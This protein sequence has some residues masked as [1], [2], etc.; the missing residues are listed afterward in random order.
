MT[1]DLRDCREARCCPD[2]FLMASGIGYLMPLGVIHPWCHGDTE[3]SDPFCGIGK[4]VVAGKSSLQCKTSSQCSSASEDI[5]EPWRLTK[6]T[7]QIHRPSWP[8]SNKKH[9][10]SWRCYFSGLYIYRSYC[11]TLIETSSPLLWHEGYKDTLREASKFPF[12]LVDW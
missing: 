12:S 2:A 7:K 9:P 5:L 8:I 6:F 11:N 10:L 4:G 1:S 3:S